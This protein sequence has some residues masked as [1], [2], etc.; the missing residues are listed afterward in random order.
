MPG[1]MDRVYA[2]LLGP[3]SNYGGILD[4]QSQ[5]DAQ[6]QARMALA[7]GLLSA[8][9]YSDR[10]VSFGQALGTGMLAGQRTQQQ[11]LEQALQAN[12]VKSR[13]AAQN[14]QIEADKNRPVSDGRGD[15]QPGDYTTGSWAKFVAG[16][17]K[18]P[19]VLERYVTPRQETAKPFQNIR[20]T[21]QDGSTQEGAF[22]ARTGEFIATGPVIP[23]G[24]KARVDAEASAVGEATGAQASKTPVK[25]SMDYVIGQFE[26]IIQKTMQ[27]GLFGVKGKAGS[28]L[29]KQDKE[30]FDN[31]REQ[32]STE[33]R[34]IYRIPGEGALSDREQAQYG[35]QL[36]HTDN[37]PETNIQI[38]KDLQERT[39]LR[40][41]TPVNQIGP[42]MQ[43]FPNGTQDSE[44]WTV[45]PGGVRVRE[46][47]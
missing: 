22:D 4:Q 14:A 6:A 18:D 2:G 7:A 29:D 15:Y 3:A 28:V 45:L 34:T 27:G 36:P 5:Q 37:E 25:A 47:K 13:I 17:M 23:A 26:P 12:L 21:Y 42:G 38:L 16:D 11:A 20:R 9:G 33:L 8:G 46:K 19:S 10:P 31:L 44:G 30:R 40:T 39:R 43:I 41:E 35:I 24:T 1:I 32:L